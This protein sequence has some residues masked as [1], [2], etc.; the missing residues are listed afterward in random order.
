MEYYEVSDIR[1]K[2]LDV[3]V[4]Y[5]DS[6]LHIIGGNPNQDEHE[7]L[8]VCTSRWKESPLLPTQKPAKAVSPHEENLLLTGGRKLS[9]PHRSVLAFSRGN[10]GWD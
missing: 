6:C 2:R 3:P 8:D 4:C 9:I 1:Y 10:S 5:R 7:R